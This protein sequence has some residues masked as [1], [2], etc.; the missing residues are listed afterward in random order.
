[1]NNSK[2]KLNPQ[3][4]AAMNAACSG[5]LRSRYDGQITWAEIRQKPVK[6]HEKRTLETSGEGVI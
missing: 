5:E 6:D 4:V 1:M 2:D 3:F